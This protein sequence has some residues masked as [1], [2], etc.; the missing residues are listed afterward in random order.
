MQDNIWAF[1]LYVFIRR[2][3][4]YRVYVCEC[5]CVPNNM[6]GIKRAKTDFDNN[7]FGYL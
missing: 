4:E 3:I 5:A 7:H 6:P 1:F 2:R